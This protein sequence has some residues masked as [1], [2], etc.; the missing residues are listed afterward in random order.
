[1]N[2]YDKTSS[3]FNLERIKEHI[4]NRKITGRAKSAL[5]ISMF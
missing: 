5:K 4:T 3:K 1:M 2:A